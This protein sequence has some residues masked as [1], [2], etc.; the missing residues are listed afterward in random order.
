MNKRILYPN[1][2]G[3]ALLIP[4]AEMTV[5]DVARKDVPAGEPFLIVDVTELPDDLSLI[6]AWEVDFSEPDGHGVGPETWFEEQTLLEAR[7]DGVV[8]E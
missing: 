1:E 2:T 4:A 5:E 8:D 3:V 6:E 7:D